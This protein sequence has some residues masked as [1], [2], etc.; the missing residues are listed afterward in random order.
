MEDLSKL[1]KAELIER[2]NTQTAAATL[3]GESDYER[4]LR[5]I[6]KKTQDNNPYNV[7]VSTFADHKNIMLYTAINKRVGPLHPNNARA[8]MERWKQAGIQLYTAPRTEAQIEAFKQTDEYKIHI[9]KHEATRKQRHAQSGKGK[10]EKMM[11]EIAAMTAAAVA[12]A[13]AGANG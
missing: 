5:S 4:E 2:L 6:A 8:T 3:G 9:K 11:K 12:G 7:P 1:S 13:K 10:T